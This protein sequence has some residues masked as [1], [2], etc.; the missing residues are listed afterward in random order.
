M[1][2]WRRYENAFIALDNLWPPEQRLCWEKQ[3]LR[4]CSEGSC[5]SLLCIVIPILIV[6]VNNNNT[7]N[8]MFIT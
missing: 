4:D 2:K 7:Y 5:V 8:D 1:I 6:I 3:T